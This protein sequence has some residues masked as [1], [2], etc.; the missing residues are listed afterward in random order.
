MEGGGD[1]ALEGQLAR[2]GGVGL[3]RALQAHG[4]HPRRPR[5]QLVAGERLGRVDVGDV[6]AGRGGADRVVELG[7]DLGGGRLLVGAE[8]G[9]ALHGL[10]DG[11]A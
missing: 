1:R 6:G 5:A 9:A 7:H 2:G 3:G 10:A 11:R 4:V 8:P